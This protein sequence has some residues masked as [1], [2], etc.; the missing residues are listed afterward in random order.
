[1]LTIEYGMLSYHEHVVQPLLNTCVFGIHSWS[2]TW[3]H[4]TQKHAFD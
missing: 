2:H 1:M 3:A 4:S